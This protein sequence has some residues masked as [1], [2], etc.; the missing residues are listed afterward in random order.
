MSNAGGTTAA[1]AQRIGQLAVQ[2]LQTVST[3]HPR[4]AATGSSHQTHEDDSMGSTHGEPYARAGYDS[5]ADSNT[6]Q[7]MGSKGGS[8]NNSNSQ[9]C[10][11]QH[12]ANPHSANLH[13]GCG[14]RVRRDHSTPLPLPL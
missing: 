1:A 9:N 11:S 13:F 6:Q 7:S 14:A 8:N 5:K 3:L 2:K 4:A 10:S 12:S